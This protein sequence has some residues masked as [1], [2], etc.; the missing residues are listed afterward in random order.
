MKGER[1]L[2]EVVVQGK[3]KLEQR[4]GES[5]TRGVKRLTPAVKIPQVGK[6]LKQKPSEARLEAGGRAGKVDKVFQVADREQ[7]PVIRSLLSGDI[8][9]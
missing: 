7:D 4:W 8:F 1:A 9:F 5:K 3:S 2:G 6:T